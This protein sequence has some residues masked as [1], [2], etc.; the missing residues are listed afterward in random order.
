MEILGW[1]ICSRIEAHREPPGPEPGL[2][3]AFLTTFV[4]ASES[5]DM[6]RTTLLAML[7]ANYPHD[8]WVLD[9]GNDPAVRAMCQLLGVGHFSR[10]G[11]QHY[12][13]E[14]GRFL[15]KS[16]AGN[17]N[18]WYSQYANGYDIV[19]QIDSDFKVRRDFLTRT[20]GYFRN[21]RVAFVGTP[22]IY[23]NVGNWIARGAAQQTY[24]FYGP[25][26]R[27]LSRLRM[28]LLIGANHIVRVAALRDVGWY[29]GHLTEDLATGMRFH[30]G[31]WES[32]YVPEPLAIGEG[33]ISW[34]AYF[35]Q[36]YRWA[37]GCMNIF[38]THAL[39]LSRRMRRQHGLLYLLLEQ[40]YFS[41]LAMIVA[42]TL[43]VLYFLFGWTPADIHLEQLA[44]SYGPLLAW[45]QVILFW[46][47]RFNVRP[48]AERGF[49]WAGRLLTIAVI[50]IYF[51][52]LVGVLCNKRV[53]FK[54]TPKGGAE[55]A[56][57]DSELRIFRPH[58]IL[59]TMIGAS[60]TIG[61]ALG[62]DSGV[63]LAW[64]SVTASLLSS[65]FLTAVWRRALGSQRKEI[66]SRRQNHEARKLREAD[67][68]ASNMPSR[69]HDR[70]ILVM[71]NGSGGVSQSTRDGYFGHPGLTRLD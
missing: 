12:H 54:T 58:L 63:F 49:C 40:F 45:R 6:L 23:G 55:G 52:A 9:E 48:A 70:D 51:L 50:P 36:Q 35:N 71:L 33:P 56:E 69:R 22:Q 7:A 24:L 32:V 4:P 19:A 68:Y 60:L 8:T 21:S 3:V 31:R 5:V 53:T 25:I 37:F 17:H 10:S 18:A 47:Q 65:F 67:S 61:L 38:F 29:Q 2:R 30:A 15:T 64:G 43:L 14:R 41:G 46:L 20:L 66:G 57:E 62:H 44:L 16:K 34:V 42:I 1:L 27:A 11:I 26:M 28:T 13:Q 39:G 59:A